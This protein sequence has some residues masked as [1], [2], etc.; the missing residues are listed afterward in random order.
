M[1]RE[2]ID[3]LAR[4]TEARYK[5]RP[6]ALR[7]R[8]AWLALVGYLGF[9]LYFGMAILAGAV[10]FVPA[11]TMDPENGFVLMI[12][13]S[14][15]LAA[16]IIGVGSALWVRVPPPEGRLLQR[17]EAPELFAMLD[18]LRRTLRSSAFHR[19]LILPACNAAVSEIPR[20]GVLGWPRF[21]LGIGLPL[22]EALSPEELRSVLAHEAAHLSARHGR[23][24]GWIYRVRRTWA[25]G[26][27]ELNKPRPGRKLSL[28]PFIVRF[29]DWFWP[30][31]NACAFVL[32]RSNEFEA[33][34]IA[35]Q[36]TGV[37]PA[38]GALRNVEIASRF[39]DE[40]FWPDLWQEANRCEEPP[41][42]VF[43]R[44][45][46][47]LLQGASPEETAR[48]REEALR[49][50]TSTSDTHPCL[51]ERLAALGVAAKPQNGEA[52]SL[53]GEPSAAEMLLG[54]A[55]LKVRDD[56]N[57]LWK[58]ECEKSWRDRHS[59]AKALNERLSRISDAAPAAAADPEALWDRALA[60][61]NLEGDDA[62]EELLYELIAVRP[63]HAGANF[64]LG[65]CLL[66]KG[67]AAGEDFLEQAME[68]D[69]EMIPHAIG[70]LHV[71]YQRSGHAARLAEL[72]TRLDEH[73]AAMI[74]AR[75]E[76]SSVRGR[77]RFLPHGL[78]EEELAPL[79]ELLGAEPVADAAE[80]VRKET[81][82]FTQQRIFVL[83]V[84]GSRSWH[85]LDSA[86][87]VRQLVHRLVGK[88]KV[89]GR[90][91]ICSPHGSF[92]AV[93][94]KMSRVP[95]ALVYRRELRDMYEK[96]A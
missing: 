79:R 41:G 56:L 8:V 85:R 73:E 69:E 84:R 78:S 74:A 9:A 34:A 20:L 6:R 52:F 26:F 36:C 22:M 7:L 21:Y 89:P 38:A 95:G 87:P 5:D 25:A 53:L 42:D 45:Q 30:R 43:A 14:L 76:R 13:G 12:I 77:D 65:R 90:L 70:L 60:L 83:C 15:V 68:T 75:T 55:Y 91:L 64:C 24:S 32:S 59:R 62:A 57:S 47:A 94:A 33:D 4:A 18:E 63:T 27:A 35:A 72:R 88:V 82:H 37:E 3:R 40:K 23:F 1:T 39:L 86:E 67:D 71:H 93:R 51:A 66:A 46:E 16:G 50:S 81:K 96:K 29:I 28:R 31:F 54:E 44:L 48:W 49:V 19:V 80:L 10:F 58:S 2:E 11:L 17:K 61:I 92:R